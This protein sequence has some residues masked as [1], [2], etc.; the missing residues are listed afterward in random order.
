MM[1]AELYRTDVQSLLALEARTQSGASQALLTEALVDDAA[2]VMG[3]WQAGELIGYALL[4]RLPFDA[5]LQAIGVLPERRGEGIGGE[6]LGA[7]LA[8]A[9][10]W[11][12]ERVLLEV[13]ESNTSA[14]KLYAGAGFQQDG[15]R[16]DYYPA[17]EGAAGRE[18]A[19]LM[20]R[21]N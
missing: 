19:L 21:S 15:M 1:I 11:Q 12:S 4:A 5:E 18:S 6:L 3:C 16:R 17:A 20:S 13:R 9:A 10:D 8:V 14:R 7:V 2:C